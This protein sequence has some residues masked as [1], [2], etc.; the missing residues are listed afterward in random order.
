MKNVSAT[1]Q[2]GLPESDIQRAV[3][4]L[5]RLRPYLLV[6]WILV[7]GLANR[8]LFPVWAQ[9]NPKSRLNDL[10]IVV[11]PRTQHLSSSVQELFYITHI[12]PDGEDTYYFAIVDK[13]TW[14]K[15]DV[16]PS[17][18]PSQ[19]QHLQILEHTYDVRT[20]PEIL[21]K[22]ARDIA[23]FLSSGSPLEPKHIVLYHYLVDELCVMIP[24]EM[25]V[26]E[27]EVLTKLLDAPP[28]SQSAY[29][30]WIDALLKDK[31]KQKLIV[32]KK[33]WGYRAYPTDCVSAYGMNI[34]DE[35]TFAMI[36]QKLYG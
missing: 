30:A 1:H 18:R 15:V 34:V 4:T 21:L 25:W 5:E 27:C 31:D 29:F 23:Y 32:E 8:M 13:E 14:V 3:T 20:A 11:P 22:V 36:T 9:Q 6:P 28:V 24:D 19:T 12:L 35:N 33:R 7:G 26:A 10:D 16:F 17:H 2:T